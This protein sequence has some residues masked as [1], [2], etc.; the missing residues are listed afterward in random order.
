MQTTSTNALPAAAI[1]FSVYL[2]VRFFCAPTHKVSIF[3]ILFVNYDLIG[4]SP[5]LRHIPTIGSSNI[6]FSYLDAFRY[7]RNAHEIVQ[8]GY[9]KYC[10]TAF[11]VSTMGRWLV[12]I[13]GQD[14]F[15]DI[16]RASDDQISFNDAVGEAIQTDYTI[17]PQVRTDPYHTA[18]VRTPLTRNLAIRFTDIKDEISTAFEDIVPDKGDEWTSFPALS[19]IMHV[20]CRTSNRLFVGLPL[21]R[22]PDYVKLNQQ[23]TIDVIVGGQIINMFPPLL[24]PIVGRLLTNVP[25]SIKRAMVHL[26]PLIHAQ[27][28]REKSSSRDDK[29]NDL[30]SWLLDEAQGPQR[31]PRDLVIRILSINFAAIHTTSHGLTHALFYL[32]ANP[33]YVQPMREEVEAVI[34]AEGWTKLSMGKMRKVDSFIKESQRLSIGAGE[35]VA[36]LRLR[37]FVDDH[38]TL[39]IMRRKVVKDFTFSNGVTLPA[40]THLA[41]ATYATHMDPEIYDNPHQFKGFRFAEM[42]EEEGENIKHQ[43][44]S[45]SPDYLVFGAGRHACED[46]YHNGIVRTCLTRNIGVR[47]SD[48][49]DEIP[50]EYPQRETARWTTGPALETVM[51]VVC[52]NYLSA[53]HYLTIHT[54]FHALTHTLHYL[55]TYPEYADLMREEAVTAAEGWIKTVMDKM[56]KVDG[57]IKESQRLTTGAV[58]VALARKILKDFTFSNGVVVPAETHIAICSYPTHTE[59]INQSIY[60]P[61]TKL[62]GNIFNIFLYI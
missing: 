32:A 51:H 62:V 54:T 8:E 34:E 17:G 52:R 13:S 47:F 38:T 21:C 61:S 25:A 23:F 41:V 40:G 35:L 22:D 16:R 33:E 29:P 49:Q 42:R 20:V 27:L 56:H 18:I 48:N 50:A 46:P 10:G 26:G 11:K 6:L 55:A 43:I 7:F 3:S 28:E 2:L 60:Y 59:E 5:Q 14:M 53:S 4:L 36:C 9:E 30:I 39:V 37:V 15:D 12:V 19:T 24:K 57:F 45:L 58:L 44:V 31:S 1:L